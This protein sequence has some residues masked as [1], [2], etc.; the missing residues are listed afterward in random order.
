MNNS[1]SIQFDIDTTDP[2]A[3]LGFEMWLDSKL[4]VEI[5]HVTGPQNIQYEVSDDDGEH[6]LKFVLKNKTSAHTKI[7]EAGNIIQDAR[8]IV[9]NLK[10]DEIELGYDCFTKLAKYHHSYNTDNEPVV[11]TFYNEMGCNG[12]VVLNFT[13]PVYLWLLENM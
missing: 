11:E 13:T 6:E 5:D 7:D 12:H 1:V 4:V 10:F 2:A 3:K 9:K 8:L